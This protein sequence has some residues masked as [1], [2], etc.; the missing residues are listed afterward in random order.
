MA[1]RPRSL[2]QLPLP[3]PGGEVVGGGVGVAG[4]NGMGWGWGWGGVNVQPPDRHLPIATVD[5]ATFKTW[6][7]KA[8]V[9]QCRDTS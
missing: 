8:T 3:G 9:N 1:H 6:F 5:L 4:I 2:S 7:R